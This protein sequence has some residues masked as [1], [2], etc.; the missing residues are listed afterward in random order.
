M[1][2]V[3]LVGLAGSVSAT[4]WTGVTNNVWSDETNWDTGLPGDA[5][6]GDAA[7]TREI[8][9]AGDTITGFTWDQSSTVVSQITLGSDL[10]VLAHLSFNNTSGDAAKAAG[11]NVVV[12]MKK[13]FFPA[14]KKAMELM[15]SADFGTPQLVTLQYSLYVP[16]VAE[17]DEYRQP[18]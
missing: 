11:K 1:T 7:G 5:Y 8:T 17:L 15:S 10:D 4:T 3:L 6:I 2:L 12:G 13:M 9:N 16:S 18:V 14:N